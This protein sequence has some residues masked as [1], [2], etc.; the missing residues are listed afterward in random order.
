MCKEQKDIGYILKNK[1]G[2]VHVLVLIGLQQLMKLLLLIIRILWYWM[3][4]MKIPKFLK[5]MRDSV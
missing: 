2:I 5:W 1:A 3:F 4:I